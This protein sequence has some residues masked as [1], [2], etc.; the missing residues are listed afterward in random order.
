[1]TFSEFAQILY[2]CIG[3]GV[4]QADFVSTLTEEI[5]KEPS[6]KMDQKLANDGKYYL[7]SALGESM[8]NK[9]F[10]G[11][12]GISPKT[13]SKMI[14]CLDKDRFQNY[15]SQFY[16]GVLDTIRLSL[17]EKGVAI[18]EGSDANEIGSVCAELFVRILHDR[19][20]DQRNT[21]PK[22]PPSFPC[23]ETLPE[24]HASFPKTQS[25]QRRDLFIKTAQQFK[26][27]DSVNRKPAVLNRSDSANFN[28]FCDAIRD[29]VPYN[30]PP[31][32]LE[33]LIEIFHDNLL[34]QTIILDAM[35]SNQFGYDNE[36]V[37]VNMEEIDANSEEYRR[38]M[39]G[40]G[41]YSLTDKVLGEAERPL[42]LLKITDPEWG[43]FRYEMNH[44][45]EKIRSWSDKTAEK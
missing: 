39:L 30:S 10:S 14:Q 43:K 37:S 36:S 20:K 29:L 32:S 3:S 19:A 27:M 34:R 12:R 17:L 11:E 45:F 1:M 41:V 7:I 8:R 35:L 31:N 5:V 24:E 2:P 28:D 38:K 23:Q 44:L 6:L 40:F 18:A 33:K 26:I 21:L 4:K 42:E 9:I 16:D 25:T 22:R 15:I 13:A